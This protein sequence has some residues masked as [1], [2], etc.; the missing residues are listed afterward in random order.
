MG[1]VNVDLGLPM[2]FSPVNDC[3][4]A[5]VLLKNRLSKAQSLGTVQ[6][7]HAPF[8]LFTLLSIFRDTLPNPK[9]IVLVP[10]SYIVLDLNFLK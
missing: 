9:G 7:G 3:P 5:L 4:G 2:G 8:I 10:K 1:A 6:G